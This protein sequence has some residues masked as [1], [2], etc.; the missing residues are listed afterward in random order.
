MKE[1][2]QKSR[3]ELAEFKRLTE[4]CMSDPQKWKNFQENPKASL[5]Q[6]KLMLEESDAV[7][8]MGVVMGIGEDSGENPYLEGFHQVVASIHNYYE[9]EINPEKI[10]NKKFRAWYQRQTAGYRFQSKISRKKKGL[11]YIPA[12]FELSEGC[13]VGCDFCCLSAKPLKKIFRHTPENENLWKEVLEIT[14]DELGDMV[15]MSACYFASEPFDNPDYEEFL[16]DFHDQ[17]GRFPQTTTAALQRDPARTKSFLSFVGK[18]EL[19]CAALRGSI[20]SLNQLAQIHEQFSA[21]ELEYVEL[22]MNNPESIYSYSRAGRA[23]P[24]SEE[25]KDKTFTEEASSVCVCGFV[26]SMAKK[27]VLLIAPH[28]PDATHS[29]GMKVYGERTFCSGADYRRVLREMIEEYM[30]EEMPEKEILCLEERVTWERKGFTLCLRGDGI[31]RNISLSDLEYKC[32]LMLVE[33]HLP[34]LEIEQ[35]VLLTEFQK[36]QLKKKMQ[37]LYH[38]G[39]LDTCN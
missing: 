34:L 18:E 13:S 37:I 27:S 4:W 28:V 15:R 31:S 38:A 21:E 11:F 2:R 6:W 10:K 32:F 30:P 24:L 20:I 9:K 16:T 35:R 12:V 5:G 39:C 14:Q 26:V 29:M 8:A 23:I 33:E 25:L 22:L 17:F 19:A 7:E 3:K 36:Q 1:N